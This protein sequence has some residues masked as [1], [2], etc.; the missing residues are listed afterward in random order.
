[1][2]RG[3]EGDGLLNARL[4]SQLFGEPEQVRTRDRPRA[5]T[6]VFDNFRRPCRA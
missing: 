4:S 1:M 3:A 2:Q 5:E 6:N